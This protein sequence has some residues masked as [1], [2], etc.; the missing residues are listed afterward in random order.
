MQLPRPENKIAGLLSIEFSVF[1]RMNASRRR[2]VPVHDS[3][4]MS[5]I[6]FTPREVKSSLSH[7]GWEVHPR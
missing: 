1:D 5:L 2:S 7:S 3:G 4:S 6:S